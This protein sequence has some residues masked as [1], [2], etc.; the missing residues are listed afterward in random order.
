M[1][2]TNGA[3]DAGN[4]D[5]ANGEGAQGQA[6][7]ADQFAELETATREWVKT[8]HGDD[9]LKLANQAFELDKFAGNA[10]QVPK[11]REDTDAWGKLYERLGRPADAA[12]YNFTVPTDLPEAVPYN[13]EFADAYRTKAH[14]LGL[15]QEQA[16]NLHDFV[17]TE[18]TKFGT[19]LQ[20]TIGDKLTVDIEAANT[21]LQSKWGEP[22][23]ETY[24]AN[25]EMAGRFF[26]AVDE[27]GGLKAALTGA[28]LTGPDGEIL[29]PDLAFAFAKAGAAI[30]TE[31]TTLTDGGGLAGANPFADGGDLTKIMAAV[32]SD[33]A[34]AKVLAK[35]AGVDP[36]DYGLN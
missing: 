34:K 23:G 15:S 31:G 9:V 25:L 24:K 36:A 6:S 18:Q 30:F 3:S 4:P 11:D 8:R 21:A 16:S 14:E 13:S 35:Q 2:D 22:S 27:N 5:G 33:P 29:V 26:D 12:K 19:E 17:V 20:T 1:T 10:V 32:K 7:G 28:G